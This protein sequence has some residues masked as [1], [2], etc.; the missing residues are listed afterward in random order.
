MDHLGG[1]MTNT[2][3]LSVLVVCSV[4]AQA[5]RAEEVARE[6]LKCTV[7]L[8]TRDDKAPPKI[9][10]TFENRRGVLPHEAEDSVLLRTALSEACGPVLRQCRMEGTRVFGDAAFAAAGIRYACR[11]T[12]LDFQGCRVS[13]EGIDSVRLLQASSLCAQGRLY[14]VLRDET[15]EQG[16]LGRVFYQRY[17]ASQTPV[18]EAH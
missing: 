10:K 5:V 13:Y 6:P 14:R 9:R 12:Y 7:V 17:C 8:E 16:N 15:R 2:V 1:R 18:C 11:V 4:F 3:W